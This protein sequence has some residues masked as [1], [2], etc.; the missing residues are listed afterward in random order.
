MSVLKGPRRER[1]RVLLSGTEY[2]AEPA[3]K[4]LKLDDG[5]IVSLEQVQHLPPCRPSKIICMHLNYASRY[6]ELRG[7]RVEDGGYGTPN[8][9]M[10][11]PTTLNS[12][13]G[14]IV[15]PEGY[16][17][18]N[19]EG[20]IA[21]IIGRVTRNIS[22]EQAWDCIAGFTCALDM[23]LQDMRDADAGS[24]LRVKGHDGFC[25]VG[26]GIVS[27]IDVRNETLRTY[28]N[29][30]IV[31]EGVLAEEMIW[32][33]DYVL[34]DLTRHITLLPGDLVLTATPANSRPLE[35][36]DTIEVEVESIGRLSNRVVAAPMP[37]AS[38]G[39]PP[40]DSTEARR[41]SLGNDERL[42]DRLRSRCLYVPTR[43]R[44]Q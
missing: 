13:G 37:S 5:R 35:V 6:Y 39:A 28:R 10:K 20:E 14:E 31:Q 3:G 22:P 44:P 40:V 19:Y 9:F 33:F 15:R 4:A 30:Q 34:A 42:P 43:Q 38:V 16:R 32:G 18:L 12:H 29:G 25:P 2:W 17:Y 27:G 36:G 7:R 1:R 24:M 21:L 23:G 41:V 11:P 26:P 8:Y